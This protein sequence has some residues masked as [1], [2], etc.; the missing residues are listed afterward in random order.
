MTGAAVIKILAGITAGAAAFFYALLYANQDELVFPGTRMHFEGLDRVAEEYK[1]DNVI[2]NTPEGE[3]LKGWLIK[4]DRK[5]EGAA[6]G[7]P[8]VVYFGGNAEEVSG[9]I[10]EFCEA[11]PDWAVLLLN[12]RGF[13]ESTGKPTEEALEADALMSYDWAASRPDIN[14][15]M[16]VPFGRSL[17]SALAI[18]IAARR[19]VAAVVLVSP[20]TSLVELGKHHYRYV[21]VSLLLRHR[22]D[23]I[24]DAESVTAEALIVVAGQ[25]EVIPVSLSEKVHEAWA[26]PKTMLD[27]A[28]A[29]HNTIG[30]YPDYMGG[31]SGFLEEIRKAGPAPTNPDSQPSID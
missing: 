23:T 29:R 18:H 15:E 12:Y 20:F 24:A 9:N 19:P 4:P 16:I 8:L 26:G 2:L 11:F 17:G 31:I 22:F 5:P 1:V 14:P 28:G 7:L 10:P 25:D 27:I 3:V 30:M 13:G 6:S 21:P